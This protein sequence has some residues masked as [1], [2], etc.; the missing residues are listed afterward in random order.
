M[1]KFLV[2]GVLMAFFACTSKQDDCAKAPDVS[3]IEVDL[4]IDR[5]EKELVKLKTKDDIKAFLDSQPLFSEEF[6]QRSQY[7]HDSIVINNIYH[8]IQDPNI[9][10]LFE[11]V[12]KEYEDISDLEDQLKHSFGLLKHYYPDFK[13]PIVQTMVTGLGNDIYVS[14]DLLLIGLDFFIGPDAT[15]RP[16]DIPEYILKRYRR[17]YI[18]PSINLLLSEKYNKTKFQDQSMLAEMVFY[19]KAYYFAKQMTP[20][21]SDTLVMGY[22]G[23]ELSGVRAND[24]LIWAHF[25]ENNL[26]YETSHFAKNKYLGERPKT[27]EVGEKCPGRVAVWLG[28]EIV[29]RYMGENPKVT[30][31]ELMQNDNA[32]QIFMLSKYKP[33]N[34]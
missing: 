3:G 2:F 29:K 17:E 33:K 18:V 5:L 8:L 26:L 4:K 1:R 30:L 24:Y 14:D 32:Q 13:I 28:W 10:V 23:E 21:V 20:C 15:Y 19:G 27:L 9:S 25:V 6:L 7:P 31:D 16:K 11:E 12:A 34:R 22:T